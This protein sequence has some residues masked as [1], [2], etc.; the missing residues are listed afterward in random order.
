MNEYNKFNYF[1]PLL[2]F[3]FV[4][5]SNKVK[6]EEDFF[7]TTKNFTIFNPV[8]SKLALYQLQGH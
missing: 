3:R 6:A 2:S 1:F 5:I 8:K 7:L 4:Y